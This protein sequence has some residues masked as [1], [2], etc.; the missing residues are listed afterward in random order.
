MQCLSVCVCVCVCV[1][2]SVTFVHYVETNKHT[3]N[4]FHHRVATPVYFFSIKQH[5]NI[6]T[7]TPLTGVSNAGG[8]SKNRDSELISGFTAC[9]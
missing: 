5:V 6:P 7:G 4:F 3:F 9:C 1:C 8:V 2:V